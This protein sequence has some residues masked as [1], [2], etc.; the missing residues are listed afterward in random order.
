MK[1]KS[2]TLFCIFIGLMVMAIAPGAFA[3]V[4]FD[5]QHTLTTDNSA[6]GCDRIVGWEICICVDGGGKYFRI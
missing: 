1:Q 3:G 5:L 4:N 2:L 6:A